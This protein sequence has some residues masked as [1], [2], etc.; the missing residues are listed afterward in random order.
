M[1]LLAGIDKLQLRKDFSCHPPY[2]Y[3]IHQAWT[4]GSTDTKLPVSCAFATAN[5]EARCKAN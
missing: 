1:S 3:A 4:N 5:G 2:N